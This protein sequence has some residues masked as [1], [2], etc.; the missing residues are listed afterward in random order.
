MIYVQFEINKTR[1]DIIFLDFMVAFTD[2]LTS[3]SNHEILSLF[4]SI[5]TYSR[6]ITQ[7]NPLKN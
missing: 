7:R 3:Q 2:E 1:T 5:R 4:I 6:K